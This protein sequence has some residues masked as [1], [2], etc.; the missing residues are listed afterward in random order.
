[1]SEAQTI[2]EIDGITKR[3]FGKGTDESL[4]VLKGIDLEIKKGKVTALIGANG[5]GKTTL[6]NIISGFTRPNSGAIILYDDE[7]CAHNLISLPPHQIANLKV[8]RLFQDI[9]I[10]KNMSLIE[11]VMIASSEKDGEFPFSSFFKRDVKAAEEKRGKKAKIIINDLLGDT[12]T[13]E[14]LSLNESKKDKASKRNSF[15]SFFNSIT[16]RYERYGD[17]FI[18]PLSRLINND[19]LLRDASDFSFGQQRLVSLAA[20]FMG[21]YDLLLLDEPTAGV[22]PKIIEKILKAIKDMAEKSRK[23][24]FMIE[25]NMDAVLKVS[26]YCYFMDE[27]KIKHF[28]SPA[29]VLGNPKVRREYLGI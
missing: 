27:G 19:I 2:L 9:Y 5:A 29:D 18:P 25:H 22:N 16:F 14:K 15:F 24:I 13:R 17:V 8:G 20:L 11:N 21:D 23:S 4:L 26:D 10:Y 28:G 3:F 1:M 7:E 6:F 12:F